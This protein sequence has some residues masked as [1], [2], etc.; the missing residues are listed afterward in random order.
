MFSQNIGYAVRS[1]LK[2]RG[3]TIVVLV[4]LA[5]GIGANTA[6]FSLLDAVVLRRLAVPAPEELALVYDEG[7]SPDGA[8]AGTA[9]ADIYS[10]PLIEQFQ[11]ALPAGATLAAMTA[12]TQLNAQ[13]GTGESTSRVLSQLVSG[14]FSRPSGSR[15]QSV[16]C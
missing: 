5:L 14:D 1:L 13:I 12:P 16:A 6:I 3:Y 9:T 11:E 10:W 2:N 4:T 15:P 7:P 8:A